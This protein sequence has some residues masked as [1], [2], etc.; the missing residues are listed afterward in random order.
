MLLL[1]FVALFLLLID[2]LTDWLQPVRPWLAEL[3]TP[4]YWVSS[5][6]QRIGELGDESVL[7]RAELEEQ[8]SRQ[9][10]EMLILKGRIQR[11]AE[12]AAE[13]VRL[14]N[15]LNATELLR[16]SVLVTE[17]IGVSPDPS[18]HIVVLNRGEDHQVFVGQ[19]VLDADGLMG[20]VV[21]V[22][23]SSSKVLLISD[24]SHALP[25]QVLRNGVRSIAE[26]MGDYKRLSLR[27]VTPTTD[28]KVGDQLVSSGLGGRYPVGYPVGTVTSVDRVSGEPYLKV[29]LEPSARIDRSHYLLLVFSAVEKFGVEADVGK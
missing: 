26:G 19:A 27:F 16:D 4:I 9:K 11:M 22:Y 5:L 2:T 23:H 21:E 17:L 14:R 15:L 13:N 28:I 12:L 18:R 8:I 29:E 10:T 20:Q 6:P 25:V 24:L 1:V 3:T 7:S